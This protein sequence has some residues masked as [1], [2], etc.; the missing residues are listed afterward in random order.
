VRTSEDE[1]EEKERT[2]VKQ[3]TT[4]LSPHM[5]MVVDKIGTWRGRTRVR[6]GE[7]LEKKG[8]TFF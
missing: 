7:W 3:A 1:V 4:N 6:D 5:C 2:S 8:A